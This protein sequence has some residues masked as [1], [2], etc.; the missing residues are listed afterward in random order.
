[1]T[2]IERVTQVLT[3][4]LEDVHTRQK[5]TINGLMDPQLHQINVDEQSVTFRY[6][7][8]PWEANRYGQLHGGIMTA[9]MDHACGLAVTAYTGYK[10]PTLDLSADFIRPANVG[11]HLLVKAEVLSAGRTVIRMRAEIRPQETGKVIAAC[12]ANFF[13]KEA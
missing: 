8:L 6:T 11:D 2:D 1:M 7:V 12:T 10:A 9:M 5:D 3:E 13:N 4:L